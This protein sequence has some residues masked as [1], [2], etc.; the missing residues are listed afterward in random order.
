VEKE[1]VL[2]FTQ[3]KQVFTFTGVTQKPAFHS[4]GRGF[5]AVVDLDPGL[6]EDQLYK[7]LLT[8]PDGF[9]R[10][11]AGQ[12]IALGEMKRLYT[13]YAASGKMPSLN[14]RYLGALKTLAADANSDPAI[15]AEAIGQPSIKEFEAA[16]K[17]VSPSAINAVIDHMRE[18]IGKELYG[19]FEAVFKRT[20]DGNPYKFEYGEVGKRDM[21]RVATHY[22]L[23]N[24][25]AANLALAKDLYMKADNMTDKIIA[26]ANIRNHFTPEREAVFDDFFNKFKTDQLTIQKWFGMQAMTNAPTAID[27]VKKI[28]ASKTF[29]WEN[30][31][32]IGSL[33]GGFAGNYQQFHRAD[34]KGY[35]FIADCVIKLDKI[36]PSTASRIVTSLC[37]WQNYTGASREQMIG[38]L[39]RI[40]A[41]PKLSTNVADK[42]LKALPEDGSRK[43][44]GPAV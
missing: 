21:K 20:H 7:Q 36:N 38:Q 18:S 10:W 37:G 41:T 5:S 39:Q 30:P 43:K 11:D 44:A 16:L 25:G 8:D 26:M 9:N 13:E 14:A 6:T 1:R 42:V 22:L 34:G 17:P 28:M 29:N 33:I 2:H 15:I 32:H 19:D 4:L 27:N 35:E 24:G 40:A 12:K 31:G 3:A 23:A